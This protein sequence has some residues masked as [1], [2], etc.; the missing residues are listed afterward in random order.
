ME[1]KEQKVTQ[2]SVPTNVSTKYEFF[3]GFGWYELKIVSIAL[4][5]GAVVFFITGLFT[6]TVNKDINEIPLEMK[7]GLE[8]IEQNKE[9]QIK[10]TIKVIPMVVR[11]I[12]LIIPTIITFF[13]VKRESDNTSLINIV[14]S[15]ILFNKKQK[16]YIYKYN[17]GS[18]D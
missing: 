10:Q 9:G 7:I 3:P 16:L 8:E 12:F 1:D 11:I 14:K 6:K 2:Y 17:S 15:A 18:E 4:V 5:I 13:A